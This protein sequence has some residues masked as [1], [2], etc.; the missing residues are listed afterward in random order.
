MGSTTFTGDWPFE[1]SLQQMPTATGSADSVL[2]IL[3]VKVCG[4]PEN[5]I[6]VRMPLSISQA[7]Q[8]SSQLD[9]ALSS[10]GS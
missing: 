7:K 3:P 5:T 9:G 1:L 4:R 8:L 2:L 6:K 10:V